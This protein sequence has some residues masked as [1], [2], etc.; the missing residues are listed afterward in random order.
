MKAYLAAASR[1]AWV[2]NIAE[3]RFSFLLRAEM[4]RQAFEKIPR[5][6]GGFRISVHQYSG[7]RADYRRERG[8]RPYNKLRCNRCGRAAT[9]VGLGIAGRRAWTRLLGRRLAEDAFRALDKKLA[10]AEIIDVLGHHAYSLLGIGGR[11]ACPLDCRNGIGAEVR[12]QRTRELGKD[13]GINFG[14]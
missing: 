6:F 10:F 14:I 11:P 12:Q 2:P 4:P 1:I 9:R 3:K 8:L 13:R 7:E 5:I